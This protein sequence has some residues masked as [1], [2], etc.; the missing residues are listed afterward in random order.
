[1]LRP[2][3]GRSWA[4][5]GGAMSKAGYEQ[6]AATEDGEE[7]RVRISGGEAGAS[8]FSRMVFQW[9][10]PAV[11]EGACKSHSVAVVQRL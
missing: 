6:V 8:W 10:D 2:V 5:G 9:V 11:W 4:L 1:M 7:A 3:G